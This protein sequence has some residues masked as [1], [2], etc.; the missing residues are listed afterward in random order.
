MRKNG[1]KRRWSTFKNPQINPKWLRQDYLFI[2]D[3]IANCHR[4]GKSLG[5]DKLAALAAEVGLTLTADMIRS[6]L[7]QLEQEGFIEVPKGRSGPQLTET[8]YAAL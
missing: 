2:L 3:A 1:L 6:R 5:R 4:N 8:G 7:K